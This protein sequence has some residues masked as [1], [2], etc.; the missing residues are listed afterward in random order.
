M[1]GSEENRKTRKKLENKLRKI[2]RQRNNFDHMPRLREGAFGGMAREYTIPANMPGGVRELLFMVKTEILRLLESSRKPLKFQL[3]LLCVF[4]RR[5]RATGETQTISHYINSGHN[6]EVYPVTNISEKYDTL[7]AIIEKKFSEFQK[8]G[9]GWRLRNMV[10]LDIGVTKFLVNRGAGFAEIPKFLVKRKAIINVKND[11]DFCFRWA[12]TCALHPVKKNGNIPL[13]DPL[14]L[15]IPELP[16]HGSFAVP[17]KC[18][19]PVMSYS[20]KMRL[21]RSKVWLTCLRLT[22]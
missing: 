13:P 19:L 3:V 16:N 15:E 5:D 12:V 14:E 21:H 2:W 7:C 11:D 18:Q 1:E 4:E 9:S 22:I 8:K 6:A 17:V 10:R 20:D